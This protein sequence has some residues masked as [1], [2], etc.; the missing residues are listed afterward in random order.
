MTRLMTLLLMTMLLSACA[1]QP[2]NVHDICAIYDEKGGWFNNW[3]RYGKKV[4]KEF[5]VPPHVTMATIWKE[6]T[7]QARVKPPRKKIS[8]FYSR[9]TPVRC[10]WLSAGAEVDLALVSE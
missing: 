3:Y 7:F 10:L 5:G 4:E 9:S 8:R 6:S 1:S 2:S